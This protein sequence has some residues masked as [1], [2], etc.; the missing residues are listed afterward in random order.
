MFNSLCRTE[1]TLKIKAAA[2]LKMLVPFYQTTRCHIRREHNAVTES[3]VGTMTRYRVDGRGVGVQAPVGAR[4]FSSPHHPNWFWMVPSLL[5]SWYQ[6]LFPWGQSGQCVK[7][8]TR[9][10]IV[11]R[12]RI[13]GSIHPLIHTSSWHSAH[14]HTH[15]DSFTLYLTFI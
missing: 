1:D 15:T 11:L 8:T 9:L 2:S 14:T 6:G 3:H 4:F 5:F 12:S 10:H 13:C 7:L